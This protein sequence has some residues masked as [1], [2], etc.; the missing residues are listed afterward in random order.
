MLSWINHAEELKNKSYHKLKYI[1][2]TEQKRDRKCRS[3]KVLIK[4]QVGNNYGGLKEIARKDSNYQ[5][6]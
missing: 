3:N 2:Y 4:I 1:K 6:Q 5:L